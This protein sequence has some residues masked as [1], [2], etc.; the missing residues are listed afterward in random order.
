MTPTVQNAVEYLQANGYEVTDRGFFD[1][2]HNGFDADRFETVREGPFEVMRKV[3]CFRAETI[4][5]LAELAGW[6]AT[7]DL[8][9]SSWTKESG[10]LRRSLYDFYQGDGQ[11]LLWEDDDHWSLCPIKPLTR[12]D[13]G[14]CFNHEGLLFIAREDGWAPTEEGWRQ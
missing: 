14:Q 9:F 5:Q 3:P 8:D 4:E 11:E 10:H 7:E 2:E 1:G 13:R 6:T 12:A